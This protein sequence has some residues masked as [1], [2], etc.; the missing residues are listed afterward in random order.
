[1]D[2]KSGRTTAAIATLLVASAAGCSGGGDGGSPTSPSPRTVVTILYLA[3][4]ATDPSLQAQF[5]SCL[6]AVE[7]THIHPGWRGFDREFLPAFP[8][9]RFEITFA[10][11]PVGT[12]Q[13]LRISDPNAC[14][15]DPNGASTENVFANGILLTDI[16]GTPGNGTEP[17]LA[18][19][20]AAYGTV[21]P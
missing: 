7:A 9:D 12:R 3:A 10:D 11:V 15:T 21:T 20:V 16:V 19:T 1:M 4:T 17:G 13:S 14:A 5:A 8:P 2:W 18:F 6:S